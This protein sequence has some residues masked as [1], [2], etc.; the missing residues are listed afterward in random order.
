MS[1]PSSIPKWEQ[2]SLGALLSLCVSLSPSHLSP[3]WSPLDPPQTLMARGPHPGSRLRHHLYSDSSQIH[4]PELQTLLWKH[5]TF[6]L[7]CLISISNLTIR[8]LA[9]KLILQKKIQGCSAPESGQ[10]SKD[11]W[12]GQPASLWQDKGRQI[13]T[14]LEGSS[15]YP[16]VAIIPQTPRQT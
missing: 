14:S 1:F 11:L 9:V 10:G 13:R 7:K 15:L 3:H 6:T 16:I 8:P 5:F 4:L 12:V 2:G